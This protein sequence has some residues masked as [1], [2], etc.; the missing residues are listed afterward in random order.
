MEPTTST[1]PSSRNTSFVWQE[2][3]QPMA[4]PRQPCVRRFWKRAG[5]GSA[6]HL[7]SPHGFPNTRKEAPS[8]QTSPL[9]RLQSPE[10][11]AWIIRWVQVLKMAS[12]TKRSRWL[13]RL[14]KPIATIL[15]IPACQVFRFPW[16]PDPRIGSVPYLNAIPLTCGIEKKRSVCPALSAGGHAS[17]RNAGCSLV[18]ITEACCILDM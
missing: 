11:L 16:L 1:A 2:P 10:F 3:V 12:Q 18:S 8:T 15:F 9:P 7:L 13:I 17:K 5:A 6:G 14:M 4:R